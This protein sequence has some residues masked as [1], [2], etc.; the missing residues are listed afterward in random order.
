M[1]QIVIAA[2]TPYAIL[3]LSWFVMPHAVITVLLFSFGFGYGTAL[4]SRVHAIPSL[5][6]LRI[7]TRRKAEELR[8]AKNL[9]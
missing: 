7:V 2:G 5:W 3:L 8:L 9:A 6:P 1:C 4:L